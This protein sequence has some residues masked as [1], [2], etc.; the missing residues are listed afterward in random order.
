MSK[1]VSPFRRWLAPGTS[2][3]QIT[4]RLWALTIA[5]ATLL[6]AW[7]L[8]GFASL[9][10]TWATG[11]VDVGARGLVF[12]F[13]KAPRPDPLGFSLDTRLSDPEWFHAL[14]WHWKPDLFVFGCS[15]FAPG[16]IVG[17]FAAFAWY[18][19]FRPFHRPGRLSRTRRLG[20]TRTLVTFLAGVSLAASIVSYWHSLEWITPYHSVYLAK[21]ELEWTSTGSDTTTWIGKVVTADPSARASSQYFIA[22]E[23]LHF[24]PW[25]TLRVSTWFFFA[26]TFL[27]A[28]FLWFVRLRRYPYYGECPNSKCGYDRT[29]LAADAPCP[30]CG[31]VPKSSPL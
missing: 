31:R 26:L 5:A 1:R 15:L 3:P 9:G 18:R 4:R 29:G 6:L 13:Y 25:S 7:F 19:R 8:G 16:V 21:A 28:A 11:R 30:E 27:A 14:W 22:Y 10:Y 24:G 17:L 20:R 2:R 23:W 12:S